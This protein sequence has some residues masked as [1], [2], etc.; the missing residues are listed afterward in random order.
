MRSRR[1]KPDVVDALSFNRG[2][3]G[4]RIFHDAISCDGGPTSM[5]HFPETEWLFT[6][7]V[8]IVLESPPIF[9]NL[10]GLAKI[11]PAVDMTLMRR[12][13]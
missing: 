5:E 3:D 4:S 1:A 6:R 13:E 2:A 8:H 11:C 9:C 12:D 10:H 7:P